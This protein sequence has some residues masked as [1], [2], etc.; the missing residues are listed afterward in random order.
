MA[1]QQEEIVPYVQSDYEDMLEP[2]YRFRP[3]DSEIIVYY[4]KQKIE[5]GEHPECRLH[6]VNI[7]N[8]NPDE[9]AG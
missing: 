5:T 2:G 4:L 8:Y 6:Q 7:Y 1:N 9:L 3:T